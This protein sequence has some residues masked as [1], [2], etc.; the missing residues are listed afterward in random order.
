MRSL[1]SQSVDRVCA[2]GPTRGQVAG[3]KHRHDQRRQRGAERRRI[4][5][6]RAEQ[7]PAQQPRRKGRSGEADA[8]ADRAQKQA[9][10]QHEPVQARAIGSERRANA[11]LARPLADRLRDDAVDAD[12]RQRERERCER[13]VEDGEVADKPVAAPVLFLGGSS[14]VGNIRDAVNAVSDVT[15]VEATL[16]AGEVV[17]GGT[18]GAAVAATRTATTVTAQNAVAASRVF[19]AGGG[20]LTITADTAGVAGNNIQVAFVD[21]AANNS[22]LAV[23]VAG[24][25][26]NVDGGEEVSA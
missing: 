23:S 8:A 16:R 13:R 24:N 10:T 6:V 19:S 9:A 22:A 11:E 15:G 12:D 1:R 17:G 25:V 20:Q 3:Q 14:T 5:G 2:H 4:V 18:A 21:P 7:Q 26:I